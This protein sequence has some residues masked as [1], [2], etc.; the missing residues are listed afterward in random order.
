[1]LSPLAHHARR[2]AFTFLELLVSLSIFALFTVGFT[3]ALLMLND[4]APRTRN[5]TSADNFLWSQVGQALVL[6]YNVGTGTTAN[7]NQLAEVL[8]RA[9]DVK[10]TAVGILDPVNYNY[11]AGSFD[12]TSTVS[13]PY[14]L[15]FMPSFEEFDG[16]KYTAGANPFGANSV[17]RV[18]GVPIF[19]SGSASHVDGLGNMDRVTP[20]VSGDYFRQVTLTDTLAGASAAFP[21]KNDGTTV[22]D[23]GIRIVDVAVTY[24]YRAG[25]GGRPPTTVTMTTFR[26]PN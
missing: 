25:T 7:P 10:S 4:Q 2:G 23:L 6:N 22:T 9:N 13:A 14:S 8:K 12:L 3:Y 21:I 19:L 15:S 16:I 18:T 24:N 26:V 11:P 20:V 5:L 1:M 17:W